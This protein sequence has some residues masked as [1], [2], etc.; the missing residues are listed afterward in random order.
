MTFRESAIS[1]LTDNGMFDS[2][3]IQVLER[4]KADPANAAMAQRWNDDISEYPPQMQV[5]VRTAAR[6]AALAY[7]D[8]TCPQAWFRPMF[9]DNPEAE[10]T[11][12]AS[13]G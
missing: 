10:I 9:T 1:F 5:L 8:E 11:A 7:I 2:Q 13:K 3:A 6:R 4:V 12:L